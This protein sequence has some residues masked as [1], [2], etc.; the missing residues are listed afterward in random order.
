MS[1]RTIGVSERTSVTV[2]VGVMAESFELSQE[3]CEALL[4]CGVTGRVALS[5]PT[6]PHI[7]PTNY[8]VVDDAVVLRTSPY[9]VLGTY[10]RATTLAFEV[11]QVDH[12]HQ[13]GW[14]VVARGRSEVVVDA[15]EIDDIERAWPP[16]PWA[17]GNRALLL[18]LRWT[19]ISGRRLG[20]GWN[21]LD[22]VPVRR[23]V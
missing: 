21:P 12:E 18:R 15:D 4:R 7:V 11:D 9:S 17:A 10:G 23:M 20:S 16:R 5:G 8:S 19:E 2:E 6:G 13:R 22:T 1:G 14:S 3:E